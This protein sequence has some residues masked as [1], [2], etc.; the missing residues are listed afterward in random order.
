MLVQCNVH[1]TL[2]NVHASHVIII[3]MNNMDFT[4]SGK[5]DENCHVGNNSQ[6]SAQ[7]YSKHNLRNGLSFV[8]PSS[9]PYRIV[10]FMAIKWKIC[11]G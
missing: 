7:V 2:Y 8:T 9:V 10:C 3:K 1:C 4:R 5:V 11:L 6:F